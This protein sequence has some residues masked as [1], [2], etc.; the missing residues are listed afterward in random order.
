MILFNGLNKLTTIYA[1]HDFQIGNSVASSNMF[2]STTLLVGGAGTE[3]ETPFDT[4]HKNHAYAKIAYGQKGYFTKIGTGT[5]YNI[6]YNL[7]GG[8][9]TNPTYYYSDIKST[10]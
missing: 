5:R 6:T 9:A 2:N 10:Y 7:D 4:S 3:F 8:T 1:Q